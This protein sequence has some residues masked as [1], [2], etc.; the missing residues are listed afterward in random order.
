MELSA[1][2]TRPQLG[3]RTVNAMQKNVLCSQALGL[4]VP[5]S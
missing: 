4:L 3:N 1:L 5:V 2:V